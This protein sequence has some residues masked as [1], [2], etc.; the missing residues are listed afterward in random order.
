MAETRGIG[1]LFD[2][3]KQPLFSGTTIHVKG[4][5]KVRTEKHVEVFDLSGTL[6]VKSSSLREISVFEI[7]G[8]EFSVTPDTWVVGLPQNGAQANAKGTYEA[9]RR[10][11]TCLAIR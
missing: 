6:K 7:D 8:V 5:D 11:A 4:R 1:H 9:G 2:I 10:T 3:L